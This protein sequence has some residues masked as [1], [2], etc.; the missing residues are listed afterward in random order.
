MIE[1]LLSILTGI[2]SGIIASVVVWSAMRKIRPK[3]E[4]APMLSC[5][6]NKDD[7]ERTHLVKIINKGYRPIHGITIEYYLVY[8]QKLVSFDNKMP[9]LTKHEPIGV[10]RSLSI[11]YK[12][13]RFWVKSKKFDN[14]LRVWI[15]DPEKSASQ[16]R[17]A[18]IER[19][20]E[21]SSTQFM[22]RIMAVDAV[23]SIV[24]IFEQ[25]YSTYGGSI[26]FGEYMHGETFKIK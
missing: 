3:I 9:V 21:N 15:D 12:K 1:I 18:W 16:F 22:I 11:I 5:I 4:I 8:D 24:Q 19:R 17:E 20:A 6:K 26:D 10:D 7:S 2:I 23:S 14:C 25:K 13:E